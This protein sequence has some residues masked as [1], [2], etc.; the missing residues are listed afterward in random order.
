MP[1][2]LGI[3]IKLYNVCKRRLYSN[4]LFF[5]SY[6][7]PSLPTQHS[8]VIITA[9]EST[10]PIKDT[11]QYSSSLYSRK[12][13]PSH[14]HIQFHFTKAATKATMLLLITGVLY[15][16]FNMTTTMSSNM[17][18]RVSIFPV[19]PSA[20][21]Q[22]RTLT[23]QPWT[24][25]TDHLWVAERTHLVPQKR[26]RTGMAARSRLMTN[27]SQLMLKSQKVMGRKGS[28]GVL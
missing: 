14:T 20:I 22:L 7:L 25:V 13:L 8:F 17:L 18:L 11:N 27:D 9:A 21:E 1:Q 15:L 10:E 23:K 24:E 26:G 4:I 3:N 2:R 5:W 6:R 19:R 12:L 28:S 16:Y